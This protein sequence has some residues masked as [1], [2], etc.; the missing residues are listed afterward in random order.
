MAVLDSFPIGFIFLEIIILMNA[1]NVIPL[2]F[3]EHLPL[4]DI[5]LGAK[6]AERDNE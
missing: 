5:V 2:T 3:I 1:W 6:N 4:P